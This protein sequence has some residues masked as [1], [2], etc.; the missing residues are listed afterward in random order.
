MPAAPPVP[1]PPP[2]PQTIASTTLSANALQTRQQAANRAGLASTILTNQQ[3]P[4]SSLFGG[5]S[6]TGQ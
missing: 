4:A 1:P 2:P 5:K 6:L 3:S